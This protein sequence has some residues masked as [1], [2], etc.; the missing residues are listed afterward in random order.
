MN[1]ETRKIRHVIEKRFK[2]NLD[3][4]DRV[5]S[6]VESR[7][8]D[9]AF[10]EPTEV[11]FVTSL[12][13]TIDESVDKVKSMQHSQLETIPPDEIR[14]L[15]ILQAWKKIEIL[16]RVSV[17]LIVEST[18]IDI[19]EVLSIIQ[20]RELD[21]RMSRNDLKDECSKPEMFTFFTERKGLFSPI[22]ALPCDENLIDPCYLGRK[23]VESGVV[24]ST[25]DLFRDLIRGERRLRRRYHLYHVTVD[26]SV[27]LSMLKKLKSR[28]SEVFEDIRETPHIENFS[29]YK[30]HVKVTLTTTDETWTF[31]EV[32]EDVEKIIEDYRDAK[33]IRGDD[34]LLKSDQL[35][36]D[37]RHV[38]D[39]QVSVQINLPSLSHMYS[40]MIQ[41]KMDQFRK[42]AGWVA[43]NQIVELQ[44]SEQSQY[45]AFERDV[46]LD[47]KREH[48]RR[49]RYLAKMREKGMMTFSEL[50]ALTEQTHASRLEAAELERRRKIELEKEAKAWEARCDARIRELIYSDEWFHAGQTQHEGDSAAGY[51]AALEAKESKKAERQAEVRGR[52]QTEQND[53]EHVQDDH[54]QPIE[55]KPRFAT[56]V[57]A[58]ASLSSTLSSTLSSPSSLT[59]SISASSPFFSPANPFFSSLC[60]SIRIVSSSAIPDERLASHGWSRYSLIVRHDVIPTIPSLRSAVQDALGFDSIDETRQRFVRHLFRALVNRRFIKKMMQKRIGVVPQPHYTDHDYFERCDTAPSLELCDLVDRAIGDDVYDDI[61]YVHNLGVIYGKPVAQPTPALWTVSIVAYLKT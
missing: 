56:A 9:A 38:W 14:M 4:L 2:L 20:H 32:I 52:S 27:I 40:L 7:S 45:Q 18:L 57:A 11:G 28:N 13:R 29:S 12:F 58:A 24:S 25:R 30:A 46:A 49:T 6:L 44:I 21:G 39:G 33:K 5:L 22:T 53:A 8:F 43:F 23:N 51:F 55:K 26:W 61:G 34:D 31:G 3:E 60:S 50:N 59:S 16:S 15:E 19:D 36:Q 10:R 1:D 17:D 48:K 54:E 37:F 41:R 35:L 47:E 42:S